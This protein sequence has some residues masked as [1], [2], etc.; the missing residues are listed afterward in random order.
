MVNPGLG[1][2]IAP[3]VLI[4]SPFNLPEKT[5]T[6][7]TNIGVSLTIK[8]NCGVVTGIGTTSY[9]NQLALEF[10]LKRDNFDNFDTD[11]PINVGSPI[12]IFDTQV[13]SGLTSI[14]LSKNDNDTVGIG[15]SFVDN[16]YV[17]AAKSKLDGNV[18]LITTYIKDSSSSLLLYFF[19]C[20][21]I[22]KI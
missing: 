10:T 20:D 11:S 6:L 9:N 1:Y 22:S 15:T 12:Y 5:E 4:S 3:Q 19:R 21:S 8:N 16:V 14:N 2:T 18:G 13:G 7:T 17:V